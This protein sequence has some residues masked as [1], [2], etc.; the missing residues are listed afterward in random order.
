M[1]GFADAIG[2]VIDRTA[3]GKI[4]VYPWLHE[5]GLIRL[6]DLPQVLPEVAAHLDRGRWT[7]AAE[8]ALRALARS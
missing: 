2:S 7:V 8:H 4:M 3:G 6:A 5:V 1:A